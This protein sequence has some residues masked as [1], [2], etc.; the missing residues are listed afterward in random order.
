MKRSPMPP[1]RKALKR[2]RMRRAGQ[3]LKGRAAPIRAKGK[4]R[5]PK[6]EDAAYLDWIRQHLCLLAGRGCSGAVVAH[7]VRSRGAGGVDQG[8]TVPLCDGHHREGHQ[9]GWRSF[10]RTY[11][12]DL[13]AH[14]AA[15]LQR[16][17]QEH[18][19]PALDTRTE[20]EK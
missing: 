14:A 20:G 15:L 13:A 6:G 5:F 3:A 2:S 10:E 11:A 4:R 1:R 19:A 8:N 18:P 16:Y 7:H 9:V 12:A 17:D